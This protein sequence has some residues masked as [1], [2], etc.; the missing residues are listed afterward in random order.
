MWDDI[1]ALKSPEA[2]LA[3]DANKQGRFVI[4]VDRRAAGDRDRLLSAWAVVQKS[5]DE[6]VPA[7]ALHYVDSEKARADLPAAKPRSIKG[8]GGCPFDSP[9]MQELG[10]ASV[11]LNIVLNDII[12][13]EP[14]GTLR[15]RIRGT[16][17]VYRRQKRRQLRS[18]HANRRRSWLDGLRDHSFTTGSQRLKERLGS[19]C[20]PSRRRSE[21]HLCHA[22]F[23]HPRRRRSLCGG[24][25]F[26]GR[27]RTAGRTASSDESTIGFSTTK[28]TAA[29]TGR[30]PAT[31]R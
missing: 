10:I 23:H 16:H 22:E 24:D 9:D 1:T 13:A 28:S 21:R 11:T 2:L 7:S 26:S 29:S 15:L 14:P 27:A 6:F 5:G 3:I 18:I 25:E 12:Y 31:K 30:Q 17:M 19:R 4:S 8:L 20:G